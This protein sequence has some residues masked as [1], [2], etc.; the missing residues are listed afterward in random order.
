MPRDVQSTELEPVG[1]PKM[2]AVAAEVCQHAEK[3]MYNRSNRTD[4]VEFPGAQPVGMRRGH[5]RQVLNN[6][7]G[8]GQTAESVDQT[9][10]RAEYWVAEKTDGVRYLLIVG[11]CEGHKVAL[12]VDRKMDCY[13]APEGMA[14]FAD[15]FP[16]GTCLDGE[17]VQ[18]RTLKKLIFMV[19]SFLCLR[20]YYWLLAFGFH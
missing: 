7:S 9:P 13:T 1:D 18:N 2:R 4:R 15:A 17:I 5:I 19:P 10:M 6:I 11:M 14:L 20:Q 3:E 12:F 8:R 16:P